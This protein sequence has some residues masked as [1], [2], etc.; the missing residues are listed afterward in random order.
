MKPTPS[1]RWTRFQARY[2]EFPACG[3]SVDLSRLDFDDGFLPQM[4][5]PMTK[6]IEAMRWLEA[7]EEANPDEGRMVGHYW[8]R[9]PALAPSPELR[10]AI[11]AAIEDVATFAES[12][13]EERLVGERG[14]FQQA[15]VIGI[16]GSA[17]GPQFV[18]GALGHPMRDKLAVHFMDNTDPDGIDRLL[19]RLFPSLGRTLVVVISK[20][21]T[22][23]ETRNGMVETEA[24]YRRAGLAFARHAV[25]ITLFDEEAS[26]LYRRARA[27]RWL[28][29]FPMWD[30]VGGR[31]SVTSAVGLLPAALQGIDTAGLLAGAKACDET[32][33]ATDPLANPA[34]L[35]ALGWYHAG[36][37]RGTRDMVVLPYKDR[38]ELFSRYLQQL[39][40][41]SLGKELDLSG[42]IVHQGIAVYG[43]KGSTD[44]HA[45]IQQLRDGPN[46]FFA[47]FIR[48][49]RARTGDSVE[50][51]PGVTS[52][53]YLNGFLLGTRSALHERERQSIT[54]SVPELTPFAVGVLIA[55]FERAVG[56]YAQLVQINAY[57][58]PGVQA[59]KK[60]A[61]T[62]L[63]LQARI[64][65]HLRRHPGQAFD[66]GALAS[67]AES[68]D[69]ETV[70]LLAQHLAANV[71]GIRR[72]GTGT[73]ATFAA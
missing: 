48:V 39:V 40:M 4:A 30:W 29:T 32:T 20:S 26:A 49:L 1:Q 28:A 56:L 3:L 58:Q 65:A 42:R 50:V 34:A 38:L 57:H 64:L 73:S 15:L 53:D 60:A 2:H 70:F 12:I 51:E 11:A 59:G 36:E 19:G 44:Q 13:H 22:T 43:N 25:A 16:G 61:D 47:V 35:L 45:Y 27:E 31:T 66:A 72:T 54:L 14:S 9:H 23:P 21:G 6:A 71:P 18:A 62:V 69:P 37:G 63:K 33:R 52:G 17:L 68:D 8:L 46:D 55:L 24:A 41:E 67:A 10:E 5:R 7:G